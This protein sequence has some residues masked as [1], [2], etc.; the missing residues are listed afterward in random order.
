MRVLKLRR[1]PYHV[2]PCVVWLSV[3][4]HPLTPHLFLHK[5]A[6][7]ALS[8]WSMAQLRDEAHLT[9]FYEY[10]CSLPYLMSF[11][12]QSRI[13]FRNCFAVDAAH[14]LTP[15]PCCARLTPGNQIGDAGAAA[16][17]GALEPRMNGDGSWTPPTALTELDLWGE[18]ALISMVVTEEELGCSFPC[19]SSL[20]R[21]EMRCTF[22]SP[23]R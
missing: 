14:R 4:F 18:W 8:G 5:S 6:Q 2:L 22:L 17:A 21:D 19:T 15:T 11:L 13:V 10:C 12:A 20:R 23:V 3:L 1:P 9:T 7:R 16:V